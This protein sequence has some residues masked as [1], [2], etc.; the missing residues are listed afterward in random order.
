[1]RDL[2]PSLDKLLGEFTRSKAFQKSLK[3]EDPRKLTH[4]LLQGVSEDVCMD[5]ERVRPRLELIETSTLHLP[6]KTSLIL[7]VLLS[8]LHK[9]YLPGARFRHVIFSKDLAGLYYKKCAD[10]GDGNDSLEYARFCEDQGTRKEALRYARRA[11]DEKGMVEA[12]FLCGSLYDREGVSTEGLI[13]SMKHYALFLTRT[14]DKRSSHAE[15]AMLS[16]VVTPMKHDIP[17]IKGVID[18]KRILEYMDPFV[19]G[20]DYQWVLYDVV[21]DYRHK[22]FSR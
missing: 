21:V 7:D 14:S 6:E 2:F 3:K 5:M 22:L 18:P 12:A 11:A 20:D 16:L 15:Q 19:N 13:H 10:Q 4:R 9:K 8:L 17:D 1:M